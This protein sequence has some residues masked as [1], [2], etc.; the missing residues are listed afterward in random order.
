[1]SKIQMK[2]L[3]RSGTGCIIVVPIWQIG[4][5]GRQ[6]VKEMSISGGQPSGLKQHLETQHTANLSHQPENRQLKLILAHRP[7]SVRWA[8]RAS[9]RSTL[10]STQR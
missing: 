10:A 1:M 3:T 7:V 6:R 4:N 8:Q 5:S 2:T 9:S